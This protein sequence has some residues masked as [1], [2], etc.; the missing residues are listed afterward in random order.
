M[1]LSILLAIAVI[2]GLMF[3][4]GITIV[5]L[6]ASPSGAVDSI[7]AAKNVKIDP[8]G[9]KV[10]VD[11]D[12]FNFGTMERES[13][14]SHVFT[15]KN[16]GEAPLLLNKGES[17]CRCTTFDLEKTELK[18]G[19]SAT[20]KIEWHA[21]VPPGDF[22][23]SA[24]V[25]TNDPARPQ[26]S[27]RISGK[28][29]FSYTVQ[30]T[31]LVFT[32]ISANQ[33]ASAE[34]KIYSY[35]PGNLEIVGDPKFSDDQTA[36]YFSVETKP[37]SPEMIKENP[38]ATSG[39]LATV[40]IKPGLPLGTFHQ[41]VDLKLS[42]KDNPV[43]SLPI[44]GSIVSDLHVVGR[45]WDDDHSLLTFETVNGEEGAK[46]HLFILAG[47]PY[48][49]QIHPKVVSVTPDVTPPL[50]KV[51]LGEPTESEGSDQTRIPLTIEIPPGSRPAI[52]LG[53]AEG[54]LG[55]I[56]IETGHPE[57][58]TMKI[59]VRFAVKE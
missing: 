8:H 18:Q 54:K 16:V 46:A 47:G 35:R 40:A 51:T 29:T 6:G 53:G 11:S 3:G 14:K 45:G 23:Q 10:E 2:L 17:T 30:P 48:R 39:I 25:N 22:G 4:L 36:K 37:M 52:H 55:E 44:E 15:I 32:G 42:L 24:K 27:F 49:K 9:P 28:V 58:P 5:E 38:E 21:T 26:I 59:R 41:T 43:V 31:N 7:F 56:T 19:E 20:V 13:F 1:R 50:L 33:P 57:A 12:D 34:V